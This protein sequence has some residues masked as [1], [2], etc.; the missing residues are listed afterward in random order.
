MLLLLTKGRIFP[1]DM[2]FRA[3]INS[4]M[5]SSAVSQS[6]IVKENTFITQIVLDIYKVGFRILLG[7]RSPS[8]TVS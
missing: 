2:N 6:E 7:K 5:S 8:F 4:V 1:D 3:C